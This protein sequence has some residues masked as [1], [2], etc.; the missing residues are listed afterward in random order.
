MSTRNSP[1]KLAPP[2]SL[3]NDPPSPRAHRALRRLQSAHTLGQSN[4]P[5]SLISKQH[6]LQKTTIPSL[7]HP[8]HSRGRS[9]SDASN[10]TP[11]SLGAG[12]RRPLL[13][14]R[15]TADAL[16]LDRLIREGPPDGD[17]QGALQSTRMK[18][19]D[20]GIKSDTDGM[21]NLP[22]VPSLSSLYSI[23]NYTKTS[24]YSPPSASTS[25]SSSSTPPSSRPT[26]TSPS[27]IAPPP[28]P[29]PKSA[30]TPSA[31]SQPTPSSAA[32]SVKPH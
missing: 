29:T 13:V 18:I 27:S 21:V 7:P 3:I 6:A 15:P 8:T 9:N 1:T 5:P 14:K 10:M 28:P 32:A 20:Q 11:T 17:L 23:L 30:T 4:T 31:L 22:P 2:S 16:S 19:L 25:G 12:S 24:L 26:P